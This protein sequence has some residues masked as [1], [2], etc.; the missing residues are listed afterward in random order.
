MTNIKRI[1]N[2]FERIILAS[3][4]IQAPIYGGLIIASMRYCKIE[5]LIK[6]K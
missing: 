3:R 4:W 1:E 5:E 2:F 6:A